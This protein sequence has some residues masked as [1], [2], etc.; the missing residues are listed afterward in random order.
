MSSTENSFRPTELDLALARDPKTQ[1]AE[2][3]LRAAASKAPPA[4]LNVDRI[5]AL[6]GAAAADAHQPGP[7]DP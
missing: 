3:A 6:D 2:K 7:A 1:A 5:V 4:T